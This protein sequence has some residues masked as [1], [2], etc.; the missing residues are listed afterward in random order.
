MH[1]VVDYK[2]A[3]DQGMEYIEAGT[4]APFDGMQDRL[5]K[6]HGLQRCPH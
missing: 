1:P 4:V 5:R 6:K 3:I 2:A